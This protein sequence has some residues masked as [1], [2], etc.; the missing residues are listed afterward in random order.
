MLSAPV[1]FL[2]TPLKIQFIF[3][4]SMMPKLTFSE[5]NYFYTGHLFLEKMGNIV[6]SDHQSELPD[7]YKCS[8]PPGKFWNALLK[9]QFIFDKS[10][11]PMLTFGEKA[12]VILDTCWS[13]QRE[14]Y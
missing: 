7:E 6:T 2:D 1:K 4:K 13:E 12:I 10:L 8:V 5:K 14:I 11:I 9:I 3:D